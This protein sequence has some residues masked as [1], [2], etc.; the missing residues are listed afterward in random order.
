MKSKTAQRPCIATTVTALAMTRQAKRNMRNPAFMGAAILGGA[1]LSVGCGGDAPSHPGARLDF[2]DGTSAVSAAI[3]SSACK[4]TSDPGARFFVPPPDPNAVQQIASLVEA[5]DFRNA[6]RI[7]AMEATPSAVWF[8]GGSPDD[9]RGAVHQTMAAATRERRVPVL[10]A[11]DV[12]FRDCAQY[13]AGGATDTAAY[14]AWIDGFA[15]GIGAGKAVVILEPDSLGI[16][17]YNTTIFGASDWCKPTVTDALGNT[18]AAPGAD[19]ADR[20]AQLRYAVDAI[21]GKAPNAS[22]YLD[23]THSAWLGV[24]EAAYRLVT[25]GVQRAQGFFVNVSN[26]QPTDQLTQFGA[27][28]SDCIAGTTTPTSW[29]YNH[30]D[31]CPSQYNPATNYGIDYS[32]AYA[33]SVDA[34]FASM[35]ISPATHFVVDTSRN[36][37][38]TLDPAPY[39]A[40]PYDQP[41]SVIAVLNAGNWCNP[42]GAG[43]GSRPTASTGVPLADAYLWVKNP[44]ESDGSCD[45]AGGARAW[46]YSQYD[47]WGVAGDAQSQ[48]DPLWG[49]VDP[50]AGAWFPDQ[51][52]QLAEDAV[53][54]VL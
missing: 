47:P 39:A 23:G 16:I 29:A 52:L 20:Y 8:T 25:A 11:Y 30:P 45:I 5:K 26:F 53:P 50:P 41:P 1:A 42:P 35:G 13:S 4:A 31:Y 7:A 34:Q 46:D 19:P 22:V 2:V 51:A 49:M 33:A 36:G 27:W 37:Q 3:A 21:A 12:P 14:E 28:V 54:P 48:F 44:G 38:G 17:P 18:V 43:L 24:G 32:P 10:V 40:A 15:Q 6:A 9:V